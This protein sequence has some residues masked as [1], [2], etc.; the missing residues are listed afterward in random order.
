M[1]L[2]HAFPRSERAERELAV[3]WEVFSSFLT[4]GMLMTPEQIIYPAVSPQGVDIS[5]GSQI[6]QLRCCFTLLDESEVENHSC[7]FG[8]FA[9]EF[10]AN[11]LRAIGALPVVYMPQPVRDASGRVYGPSIVANNIVH[12][13]RDTAV[14]LQEIIKLR[15]HVEEHKNISGQTLTLKTGTITFQGIEVL[16][17]YLL[18]SKVSFEY[19]LNGIQ[20]LSSMFY[21]TDSARKETLLLESDLRYFL[22]REWRIVSGLMLIDRELSVE[23]MIRLERMSEFFRQELILGGAVYKRAKICRVIA[24]VNDSPFYNL[25]RKFYIPD[26]LMRDATQ[27]FKEIGIPISKL[28][29]VDYTALRARRREVKV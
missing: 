24:Q 14:L 2:Y 4:L 25:V 9:L 22:Q 17:D 13:L 3:G 23:E 8:A 20:F 11:E 16:L 1:R 18:G 6:N 29:A 21:H 7:T 26:V 28:C 5:K 12:Q 27:K 15:Q 10:D 19:M